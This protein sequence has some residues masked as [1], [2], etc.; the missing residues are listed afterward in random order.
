MRQKKIFKTFN[1]SEKLFKKII[2]KPTAIRQ[3]AEESLGGLISGD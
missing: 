2:N 1:K 3:F